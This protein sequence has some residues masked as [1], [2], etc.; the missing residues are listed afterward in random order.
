MLIDTKKGYKILVSESDLE[1]YPCMFLKGTGDNGVQAVFPKVPLGFGPDGD[2]SLKIVKQADYIAKTKGNRTFPWRY[3]VVAKDDKQ[4]LENTMT[5]RL[6]P[7]SEIADPLWIKP[8]QASWEGWNG[9]TP[10]V[11][12]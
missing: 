12:M 4:L 2:R 1:D 5:L 9:A 8:G 6:A 10:Y 3:F 7:K 11:P